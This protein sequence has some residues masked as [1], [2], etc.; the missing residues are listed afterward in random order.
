MA[1]RF[2]ILAEDG[3]GRLCSLNSKH[4]NLKTRSPTVILPITDFLLEYQTF[5]HLIQEKNAIFKITNPGQQIPKELENHFIFCNAN[6]NYYEANQKPENY[7]PDNPVEN[8][9]Y[10]FSKQCPSTFLYDEF[11]LEWYSVYFEE[12]LNEIDANAEKFQKMKGFGI[13]LTL[14]DVKNPEILH[15]KIIE[16]VSNPIIYEGLLAVEFEGI[17]DSK[18]DYASNIDFFLNIKEKLPA[19]ILFI[20]SGKILP[21]EYAFL[22]NLGIDAIDLTYLLHSGFS[23]LYYHHEEQM[24]WVRKLN[25]IEDFACSCEHC[26]TLITNF[27]DKSSSFRISDDPSNFPQIAFHNAQMAAVEITRVRKNIQRGSLS[28]YVERKCGFS[29]FLHSALRYLQKIYSKE[30]SQAQTL[31][32]E[33][34]FPC[35]SSLSYHNPNVNKYKNTLIKN[36]EPNPNT[37]ICVFLPC[38][39]TKPYSKSKSHRQF[40]KI[41]RNAAQQWYKY[42]SE[43]IITSPIGIAPRELEEVF[44]VAHYDISVTGEWDAEELRLTA[45]SIIEWVKKLPSEVKLVAYLHG[46]YRQAFELAMKKA[47]IDESLRLTHLIVNSPEDFNIAIQETIKSL[48]KLE[49]TRKI[50]DSLS[51]EEQ[52]IK[53]IADFQFGLGAGTALIGSAARFLLSRNEM[54]KTIMGFESYGNVQ[55]GRYLRNSGHI[56]LNYQGGERLKDHPGIAVTLNTLDITGTTIFKPGIERVDSGL[57][58]GD[59]VVIL[60]PNNEYLGVGALIVNSNIIPR[61]RR[62]AIVNVRKMKKRE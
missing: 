59:E 57:C 21:Y 24:E 6:S 18:M 45:D 53:M 55:L 54:Y 41:L 16:F 52:S 15:D 26:Q 31:N 36:V 46:G 44:P 5:Q 42:I 1:F 10:F 48:E 39:M 50:E 61:M 29:L 19:D 33:V 22:T 7:I 49:K 27:L 47:D 13:T 28:T 37:K 32:K 4:V 43:V 12:I 23:G 14:K 25:T 58:S 30:Y 9:C 3:F 62:G 56:Q 40:R 35:T 20:I 2:D 38:S 17:F 11:I 8:I 34:F 60:G 51:N